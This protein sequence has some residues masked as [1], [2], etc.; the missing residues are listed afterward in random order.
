ML[1]IVPG[2]ARTRAVPPGLALADGSPAGPSLPLAGPR[3]LGMALLAAGL[4]GLLAC[5]VAPLAA[6]MLGP[7]SLDTSTLL[8]LARGPLTA[9]MGPFGTLLGALGLGWSRRGLLGLPGCGGYC[10]TQPL[11]ELT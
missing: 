10:F 3:F 11:N 8:R 4:S 1:E 9:R 7:M 6:A 5:L 2:R